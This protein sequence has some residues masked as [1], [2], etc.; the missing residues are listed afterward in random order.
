MAK[1]EAGDHSTEI[2]RNVKIFLFIIKITANQG[3]PGVTQ[4]RRIRLVSMRMQVRSLALVSGSGIWRCVSCSVGRRHSSDLALQ[5]LW[6]RLAA[7]APIQ[8]LAWELPYALGT[9]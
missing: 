1:G 9:T 4:W 5:W 7:V 2:Y 6:C 3:V 8:P